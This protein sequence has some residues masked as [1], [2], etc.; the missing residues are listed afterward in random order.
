MLKLK[1]Q[2]FGHQM[3]SDSGK[4][5]DARKDWRWEEKRMTEDDMVGLHHQLW[6]WVWVNSGSWLWTGRPG[7]W[8][9][10]GLK[11]SDTTERLYWTQL[12]LG[13]A[14]GPKSAGNTDHAPIEAR[15]AD[16]VSNQGSW[17]AQAPPTPRREA[18]CLSHDRRHFELPVASLRHA[19]VSGGKAGLERGHSTLSPAR[20][21][22]LKL[23]L[24]T[25]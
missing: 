1:L 25:T 14:P 21:C 19:R 16:A 2:Y 12:P 18:Q 10:M 22:H 11:E 5:P 3:W 15:P 7:V 8:H 9:S 13:W 20:L 24:S 6:T 4:N 17:L 23:T